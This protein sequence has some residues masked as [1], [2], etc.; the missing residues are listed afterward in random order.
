MPITCIQYFN[1]EINI[2]FVV[3]WAWTLIRTV[4]Y[5]TETL[6]KPLMKTN[7][8]VLVGENW[9]QFDCFYFHVVINQSLKNLEVERHVIL[10]FLFS[11]KNV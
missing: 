3:K 5:E 9:E 6:V 2:C 11:K 10:L 1:K 4:V 8:Y 7:T